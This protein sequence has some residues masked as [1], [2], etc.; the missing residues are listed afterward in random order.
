MIDWDATV[1][2]HRLW[3][4]SVVLW[5]EKLGIAV[6]PGDGLTG[7]V[8]RTSFLLYDFVGQLR[9]AKI[10]YR[11]RASRLVAT[12]EE[13]CVAK[14]ARSARV[15]Y[16]RRPWLASP[17]PAAPAG[18]PPLRARS[19]C[20]L[21]ILP[22][23]ALGVTAAGVCIGLPLAASPPVESIPHKSSTAQGLTYP[24][25]SRMAPIHHVRDTVAESSDTWPSSGTRFE[26]AR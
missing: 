22:N 5:L 18:G 21:P 7:I 3:L 14:R 26:N 6:E 11:F 1:V 9:R 10:C 15:G 19:C 8:A 17:A 25:D 20:S 2:E 13:K 24:S 4:R 12:G 16:V 23:Q